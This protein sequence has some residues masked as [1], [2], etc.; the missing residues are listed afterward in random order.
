MPVTSV[1]IPKAVNNIPIG[2]VAVAARAG[3]TGPTGP[4]GGGITVT[5]ITEP[6]GATGMT[7]S[8]T[9]VNGVLTNQTQAR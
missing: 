1:F 6:L 4:N 3:P 7:G 8:M 2:M 5:I 9:F